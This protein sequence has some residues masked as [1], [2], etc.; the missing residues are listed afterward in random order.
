MGITK[1]RFLAAILLVIL[2][3]C[4]SQVPIWIRIPP[5][6]NPG[7]AQVRKEP[8]RYLNTKVRWGGTI[9]G[10]QNLESET[11]VEVVSRE[12]ANNGRPLKD[13]DSEGRFLARVKGFLDP[14]IYEEGR[15]FTVTGS[16]GGQDTRKIGQYRYHYP[17]VAAKHHWLWEPL[18][19]PRTQYHDPWFYDPWY[20]DPFL[21]PG[22]PYW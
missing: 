20:R 2:A 14:T 3:G 17:V 18:P 13:S 11:V 12:L 8:D 16:I 15:Q 22:Y 4:S 1:G 9:A 19:E 10:V 5:T 6:G 21:R 7:L